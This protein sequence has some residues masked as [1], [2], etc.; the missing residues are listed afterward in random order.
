MIFNEYYK[1]VNLWTIDDVGILTS[2][3]NFDISI[4]MLFFAIN[5]YRLYDHHTPVVTLKNGSAINLKP[6]ITMH[7]DG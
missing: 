3:K 4:K 5:T 1:S 7:E 2:K 6:N